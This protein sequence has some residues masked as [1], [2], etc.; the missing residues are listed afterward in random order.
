MVPLQNILFAYA[1][2]H[3]KRSNRRKAIWSF[4]GS[5][6]VQIWFKRNFTDEI[7]VFS[8]SQLL[9]FANIMQVYLV[10]YPL[11]DAAGG[12]AL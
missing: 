4:A 6:V 2:L 5:S 12:I 11:P 9:Q 1:K 7:G 3:K 10:G 8:L